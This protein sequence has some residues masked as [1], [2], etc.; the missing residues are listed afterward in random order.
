MKKQ[1][2]IIL[3][4]SI[5]VSACAGGTVGGLFPAPKIL[6]GDVEGDFYTSKYEAFRVQLPHPP[7]KSS[8]DSYEWKY[9]KVTEIDQVD[10]T[11]T[12]AIVGAVFGPGA[13]DQN[14]YHTVLIQEPMKTPKVAYAKETFKNKVKSRSGYLNQKHFE[15]FQMNGRTVFYAVYQG[16]SQYLVLSLTDNG[17]SFFVVES[18][19]FF[20]SSRGPDSID[21][22]ISRRWEK[23][24]AMLNSF[25]V[26]KEQI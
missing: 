4:F 7:S 18:D 24:N 5:A 9:T 11:G 13:F 20:N 17:N 10:P 3:L 19:V 1:Y 23:F 14:L 15:T 16:S 12:K 22:L 26:L 8:N 2:L 21:L 25:T 6:S